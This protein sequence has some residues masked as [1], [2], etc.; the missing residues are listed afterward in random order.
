MRKQIETKYVSVDPTTGK[1][2]PV[3]CAPNYMIG[4]GSAYLIMP[5]LKSKPKINPDRHRLVRAKH[6]MTAQNKI[7]MRKYFSG[8]SGNSETAS[9][10][11]L[12]YSFALINT[13]WGYNG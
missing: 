12:D 9:L 13:L 1:M 3:Y 10:R 8:E 5:I 11:G 2:E 6:F 4:S 7:K